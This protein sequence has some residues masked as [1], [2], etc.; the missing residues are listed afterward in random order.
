[1]VRTGE[2]E[3]AQRGQ[4]GCLDGQKEQRHVLLHRLAESIGLARQSDVAALAANLELAPL[5]YLKGRLGAAQALTAHPHIAA[6]CQQVP[7]SRRRIESAGALSCCS[8]PVR[9]REPPLAARPVAHQLVAHPQKAGDVK[10]SVARAYVRAQ[11]GAKVRAADRAD[12]LRGWACLR[13]IDAVSTFVSSRA[14]IFWEDG[15]PRPTR[16]TRGGAGGLQTNY[17]L[18]TTNYLV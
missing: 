17:E 6:R 12:L 7:S 16:R 3:P 13:T 15:P 8:R 9:P 1:M 5:E 10:R 18:T 14:R 11:D 2:G 4:T